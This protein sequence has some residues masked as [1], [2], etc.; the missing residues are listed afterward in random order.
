MKK[1]LLCLYALTFAVYSQAQVNTYINNGA[2]VK[3]EENTLLYNKG[4]LFINATDANK[5]INE[6][7]VRTGGFKKG[8]SFTGDM[9]GTEFV[10]VWTNGN[11][12]GSADSY[13]QLIIDETSNTNV[14]ARMTQQKRAVS[15]A[16]IDWYPMSLPF[17]ESVN[18]LEAT[19]QP[20]SSS[21]GFRGICAV[22]QF[23]GQRYYQTLMKWDN[24]Q[25]ENDAVPAG[26]TITP[27]AYYLLNLQSGGVGLTSVYN[28]TNIIPY[29]G[30]PAPAAVTLSTTGGVIR[31]SNATEFAGLNY[32]QWKDRTNI[33]RES[34]ESYLGVRSDAAS[35]YRFGKNMYRFGNPYTS[36]ID[37]SIPSNWLTIDNISG[38]PTFNI[39]KTSP[40]FAQ[41]WTMEDGSTVAGNAGTI[42]TAVRNNA[43]SWVGN[44]EALIIRPLEMFRVTVLNM[45]NA[46]SVPILPVSVSFGTNVKTFANASTATVG[47]PNPKSSNSFYQLEVGLY[48][49]NKERVAT[50]IYLGTSNEFVT[51]DDRI[52]NEYNKIYFMEEDV[53][54]TA[55]ANTRTIINTF[56]EDYVNKPIEFRF[57]GV[58]IGEQY[59]L[60][61]KL[62]QN[63]IFTDDVNQFDGDAKFY[64]FD[65]VENKAHEINADFELPITIASGLNSR[66]AFYWK[67]HP[68]TLGN[69]DF[70]ANKLT[71]VYKANDNDYRV[72][73]DNSKQTAKVEVY[74]VS[75]QLISIQDVKSI[76]QD[77]KLNLGASDSG[78]YIIKTHYNDGKTVTQKLLVD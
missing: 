64:L 52:E 57:Y 41:T 73:F 46:T 26:A 67:E 39:I 59:L 40:N 33:Y 25:I 44:R 9:A 60:K 63:S 76:K 3:I 4:D 5:V 32:G 35:L 66:Y 31:N 55:I 71:T 36:N 49:P 50:P 7:N 77:H 2:V 34:Y 23:C 29:K 11:G 47:T 51:A 68:K 18:Y 62:K 12:S 27:G 69:D 8:S 58:N 28:G 65:K 21:F 22:D 24:D 13:G 78:L 6:G 17:N 75:G 14:T 45:D 53:D 1:N 70:D 56:N 37:L 42:Y 54:G 20:I 38:T 16:N 10:N 72:K 43:G 30:K 74:S 48:N 61:F 19:F 15:S